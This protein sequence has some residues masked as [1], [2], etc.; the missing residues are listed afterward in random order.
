V[1]AHEIAHDESGHIREKILLERNV[2][3][4]AKSKKIIKQVFGYNEEVDIE[5]L[6]EYRN[7]AY[8]VMRHSRSAETFA[9]SLGLVY[10]SKAGY[11]KAGALELL[12]LLEEG[13]KPKYEIGVDFFLPFNSPQYPFQSYWLNEKPGVY[14]ALHKGSTNVFSYDSLLTHPDLQRRQVYINAAHYKEV[15]YTSGLQT[16]PSASIAIAEL[17]IIQSTFRAG[18]FDLTLY[19]AMQ[20]LKKYPDNAFVVGCIGTTLINSLTA[21]DRNIFRSIVSPYTGTYNEE[22]RLMNNLYNLE[23]KELGE[24]AYHFM[25]REDHFNHEERSHYYLL[26]RIC[27]LTY[28]Y[29]EKSSLAKLYNAKFKNNI[30]TFSFKN[31]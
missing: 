16:N 29:D 2:K 13:G 30:S 15:K 25:K 5:E 10:L 7:T 12:K 31:E 20:M 6:E 24:V 26:W 14:N 17:Q 19:Y 1:L 11:Q 9:D 22:Q 18:E 3:L 4:Q 28:R 27:D 8:H 21:K 23:I